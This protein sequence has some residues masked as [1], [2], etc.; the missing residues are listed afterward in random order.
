MTLGINPLTTSWHCWCE[1]KG[2]DRRRWVYLGLAVWALYQNCVEPS[3][4]KQSSQFP[5][6]TNF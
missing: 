1:Q 2:W 6:K 4:S 3:C 5:F